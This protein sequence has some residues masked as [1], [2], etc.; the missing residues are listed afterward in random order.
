LSFLEKR[1]RLTRL[2]PWVG[3]ML[4]LLLVALAAW[5]WVSVPWLIN[6]WAVSAA[7]ESATLTDSTRTLMAAMLPVVML[8]L[9]L[10]V[11]VMIVLA[12]AAFS[13]ER[14]LIQLLRRQELVAN[15]D[16]REPDA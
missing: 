11:A 4:L 7:L 15:K 16:S 5:L 14:R 9:L 2:W 1:R 13:N 3:S 12:F 6:P 10:V 8:T